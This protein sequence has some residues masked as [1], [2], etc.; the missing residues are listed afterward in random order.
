MEVVYWCFSTLTQVLN[1]KKQ[2]SNLNSNPN[3]EPSY[4]LNYSTSSPATRLLCLPFAPF[5]ETLLGTHMI[6]LL[7]NH[8]FHCHLSTH[9]AAKRSQHEAQSIKHLEQREAPYPNTN[10]GGPR[11]PVSPHPII[12]GTCLFTLHV[13]NAI[14]HG[15]FQ[16]FGKFKL[17]NM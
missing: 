2:L 12:Q 5:H 9:T 7:N 17:I 3:Q 8:S 15:F 13:Y 10:R 1:S 6:Y 11:S 14:N 4:P 16:S